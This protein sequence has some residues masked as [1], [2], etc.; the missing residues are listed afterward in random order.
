[1]YHLTQ[2]YI[3]IDINKHKYLVFMVLPGIVQLFP[4]EIEILANKLTKQE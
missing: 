4:E 1:M 2:H 3:E